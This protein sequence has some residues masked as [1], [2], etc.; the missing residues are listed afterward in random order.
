MNQF[1]KLNMIINIS[2]PALALMMVSSSYAMELTVPELSN[3]V[4]L[5]CNVSHKAKRRKT[6]YLPFEVMCPECNRSIRSS[7][8]T[9]ISQ[10]LPAHY[11]FNHC[12]NE[13]LESSPVSYDAMKKK[14]RS[15]V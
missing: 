4:S 11:A 14:L 5:D 6:T 3:E 15:C 12:E 8:G 10:A 7:I 13:E 1:N 2:V 9:P